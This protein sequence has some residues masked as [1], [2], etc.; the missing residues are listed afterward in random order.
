MNVNWKAYLEFYR[1]YPKK[2][3]IS[4]YSLWSHNFA[5]DL[6]GLCLYLTKQTS[7]QYTVLLM[8]VNLSSYLQLKHL[9]S[10]HFQLLNNNTTLP[11]TLIFVYTVTQL[12][13]FHCISQK[14]RYSKE[15]LL[16][17]NKQNPV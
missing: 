8:V 15:I 17:E 11:P 14:K 6:K 16:F 5:H 10:R 7:S 12:V 1:E 9:R 2:V 13:N 3:S 4:Y